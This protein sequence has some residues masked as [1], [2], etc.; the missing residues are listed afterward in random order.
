[1]RAKTEVYAYG[2]N[3]CQ[4]RKFMLLVGDVC[5]SPEAMLITAPRMLGTCLS[6]D[7]CEVTAC[8]LNR[9]CFCGTVENIYE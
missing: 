8:Y 9:E 3:V 5:V 6:E 4:R 2:R 7:G 1:M